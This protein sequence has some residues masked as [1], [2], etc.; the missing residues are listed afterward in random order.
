[1]PPSPVLLQTQPEPQTN[2]PITSTSSSSSS[3]LPQL[4]T[5]EQRSALEH[6]HQHASHCKSI[7]Y[8]SLPPSPE[9]HTQ[10]LNALQLG[11]I[12]DEG[13][14]FRKRLDHTFT[15]AGRHTLCKWLEY[16]LTNAAD[17]RL[18][19]AMRE[20][21][22]GFSGK[23]TALETDEPIEHCTEGGERN[24]NHT[25]PSHLSNDLPRALKLRRTL[26]SME[27]QWASLCWCWK[28]STSKTELMDNLLFSGIFDPLNRVPLVQ[29]MYHHMCVSGTP[30]VHCLAPIIPVLLTYFM[31]RW[32]GAG[33]SFRECWDMSTGVLK[34]T[35]W[36]D[37]G[38]NNGDNGTGCLLDMFFGGGGQRGKG[39]PSLVPMLMKLIKWIWWV[40]FVAN[41]L[42][43][44]YQCYRHYK[45]LSYVYQR[46]HEA[47]SWLRHARQIATVSTSPNATT[48]AAIQTIDSWS[49]SSPR[50]FTVF[51]HSYDFLNA[52]TVLR[53]DGVR[54]ECER[55]A[56]QVGV[57][58]ALQSVDALLQRDEFTEPVPLDTNENKLPNPHHQS[59]NTMNTP[60]LNMTK[61][62]HPMLPHQSQ[63]AHDIHLQKHVVLTGSNASGKSTAL[64]M[65]L[66][67]VLLA[68]SWGVVCA[69]RMSWTPFTTIRGYLFTTDECGRESLFQAQIRRIEE[70]IEETADLPPS[71]HSLL[72]V[73]EILNSTNPIEAMLLSYQYA[74]NIGT[75][76]SG[77]CRM[78]MTTHYPVLTTLAKQHPDT[79]VNWAMEN[80]YRLQVGKAC[81]ASSAIGTVHKMTRVLNEQ[82]HS[83]LDRAYKRMYKRLVK[84]RFKELDEDL[85]ED[86]E[87]PS[88][89]ATTSVTNENTTPPTTTGD[90]EPVII[91]K[92]TCTLPK[93]PPLSTTPSRSDDEPPSHP[94][95]PVVLE[96]TDV[97][98][99]H[100]NQ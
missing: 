51:T 58:D 11:S 75:R 8:D 44:V 96:K 56:R 14:L 18:R 43:I 98:L 97:V 23:N 71:Q 60:V 40:V 99:E 86:L 77:R 37:G 30:I 72:V 15:S 39:F 90:P 88:D 12:H 31:L 4:F 84:M 36:F 82:E 62:F 65:L 25:P 61:A 70:F 59:Q 46:T 1:M 73:D 16:P 57:I 95:P 6:D 50:F 22:V 100:S 38:T 91:M 24:H 32:M 74:R 68:Q 33:M 20:K 9:H 7:I 54:R 35:L 55:L 76:L 42:F 94:A 81:R 52:Y 13:S 19:R 2:H 3:W 49:E 26:A 87:C 69:K 92:D 27:N 80:G 66:L 5:D 93:G 21:L 64:K 29:N 78:V 45:L 28:D 10:L 47:A 83:R 53:S 85:E 41:I 79:F 89:A 48:E 17:I 67:N 34:N 63:T